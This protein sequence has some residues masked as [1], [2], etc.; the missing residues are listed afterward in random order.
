MSVSDGQRVN[1]AVTNNAFISRIVNSSTIGKIDLNNADTTSI[2][3]IQRALNAI[4]AS[5]GA[6][7]QA[8]NDPTANEYT[9]ERNID[10]GDSYK[11]AID[12]L[13]Q[14]LNINELKSTLLVYVDD[15]AFEVVNGVG[16]EGKVYFNSTSGRI[17]FH[18]GADW[19]DLGGLVNMI[20]EVPAGA[21]NGINVTFTLGFLPLSNEHVSIYLNGRMLDDNEVTISGSTITLTEAP[22][23]GQ[24]IFAWYL[25]EGVVSSI[26]PVAGLRNVNY[27]TLDG[28]DI[29]NKEITLVNTPENASRV[30][31]DV[32]S[33]TSQ[34]FGID[35]TVSGSVLS[36]DTLGLDGILS[37][38][39]TLRIIYD[40]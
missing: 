36:W 19:S 23:L 9:L 31:L 7:H 40:S 24:S 29:T 10:N 1:A 25:N 21:I 38:G 15:A 13:D 32:I 27:I 6:S 37:I 22:A 2:I 39:D 30:I 5:I 34:F 18:D 26:T 28:T 35:Y 16:V 12:K 17:R 3:G 8:A 4:L 33:G 11:V 14:A 20:R